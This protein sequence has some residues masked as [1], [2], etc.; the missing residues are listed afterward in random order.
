MIV[1]LGRTTEPRYDPVPLLNQ[2]QLVLRPLNEEVF[3]NGAIAVRGLNVSWFQVAE[4]LDV[5]HRMIMRWLHEGQL[6]REKPAEHYAHV[7]GLHPSAL[8]PE[9]WDDIANDPRLQHRRA[10]T[11]IDKEYSHA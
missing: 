1:T 11:A 10:R 5:S 7:M 4:H 8:W 2:C 6:I 3:V 9:W